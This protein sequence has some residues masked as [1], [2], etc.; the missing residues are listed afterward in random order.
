MRDLQDHLNHVQNG[1]AHHIM[2]VKLVDTDFHGLIEI[3]S[4][5]NPIT[6]GTPLSMSA[7]R[8]S[9]PKNHLLYEAQLKLPKRLQPTNTYTHY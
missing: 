2:L 8:G 3:P 9:S 4:R 5:R 6:Q 7:V 1:H